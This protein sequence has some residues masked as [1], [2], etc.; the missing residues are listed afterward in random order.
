L[1]GKKDVD[2]DPKNSFKDSKQATRTFHSKS[3]LSI[4]YSVL[5]KFWDIKG[6]TGSLDDVFFAT[7]FIA[8]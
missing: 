6:L 7:W 1:D 3:T 4:S 2:G 8:D 5:H